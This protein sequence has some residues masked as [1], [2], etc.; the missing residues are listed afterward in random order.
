[1][2]TCAAA[3]YYAFKLWVLVRGRSQP[4]RSLLALLQYTVLLILYSV[5]SYKGMQSS[6][7]AAALVCEAVGVPAAAGVMCDLLRRGGSRTRK[8]WQALECIVFPLFR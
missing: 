2:M 4:R 1:M 8:A 3:G 5:S 6:L 7:L